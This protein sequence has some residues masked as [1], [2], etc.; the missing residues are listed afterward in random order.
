M[1][2]RIRSALA[3]LALSGALFSLAAWRAEAADSFTDAQKSE[4][5][6]FIRDYLVKN[7]DIIQEALEELDRKQKSAETEQQK[8]T[9]ALVGPKLN[10][11]D[12]GIVIGNPN[13]DIT[14]VEF[15][16]YNCGYCK[17]AMGDIMDMI[18][19]DPKLRVILRDFPVLGPDSVDASLVALAARNQF[20]GDKYM[21]FHQN[22]LTSKG[23]VGKDRAYEVAK[24]L[25]ADMA[26]L[27]KDVESGE[28]RKLI[29]STM[30]IADQLKI[31]GTPTFVAGDSMIVGAVGKEPIAGALSNLRSCG[32]S[33][34]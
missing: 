17:R 28:P 9:L 14:L 31:G 30:R 20:S 34:C 3:V 11:A 16:D 4:L 29:E 1:M 32:K 2:M 27:K 12:E 26:K 33:V 21:E 7:P 23:R 8:K 24:D 18:K 10:S 6:S 5:G 15:F 19:A 22:L 25:G 13:G